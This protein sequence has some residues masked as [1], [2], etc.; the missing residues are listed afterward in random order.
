[1]NINKIVMTSIH[2]KVT[3][4]RSPAGSVTITGSANWTQNP[5]I[6]QGVITLDPAC[7]DF[8][9]SWI[10]KAMENGELFN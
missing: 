8:H 4:I 9:I 5:R 6:E 7:A 2:A 3:V 10:K 1:M